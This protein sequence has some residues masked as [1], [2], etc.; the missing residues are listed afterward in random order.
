MKLITGVLIL[1]IKESNMGVTGIDLGL[2][3]LGLCHLGSGPIS[4]SVLT[5]PK[6]RKGLDSLSLFINTHLKEDVDEQIDQYIRS[7]DLVVIEKPFKVMGHGK[8]L[9]EVLGIIEYLCQMS[10]TPYVLVAQ[11]TLKAFAANGRKFNTD[12]KKTKQ[13]IANFAKEDF[14]IKPNTTDEVDAFW[15]A[16]IGDCILKPRN[17]PKP[18]NAKMLK[19]SK[20]VEL[21]RKLEVIDG[22]NE[23]IL[24]EDF[25]LE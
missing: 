25:S 8:K 10:N 1:N 19:Y 7:A 4:T 24:A 6:N 22:S 3:S 12:K 9:F 11:M 17:Y 13:D 2:T 14:N 15:L 16:T 20:R 18:K 23:I 5:L 21:T